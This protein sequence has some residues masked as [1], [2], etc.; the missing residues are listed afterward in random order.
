MNTNLVDF[1]SFKDN[2]CVVIGKANHNNSYTIMPSSYLA[3]IDTNRSGSSAPYYQTIAI[4]G[5]NVSY[6][7]IISVRPS[8]IYDI[9]QDQ[10]K[11]W[12]HICRITASTNSIIVYKLVL[13][14]TQI[15]RLRFLFQY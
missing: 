15:K 5:V 7:P 13:Q 6:N 8:E 2:H 9:N 4:D 1:L 12:S 14:Y 3:T 10:I 11:A